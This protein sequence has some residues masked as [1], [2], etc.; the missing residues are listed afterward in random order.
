MLCPGV[1]VQAY[2]TLAF[3]CPFEGEVDPAQVFRFHSTAL[4]ISQ[5]WNWILHKTRANTHGPKLPPSLGARYRGVLRRGRGGRDYAG[6]HVGSGHTRTSRRPGEPSAA[7]VK[8]RLLLGHAK[9]VC[10]RLLPLTGQYCNNLLTITGQ[11][12]N[13]A[14]I[15]FG[16]WPEYLLNAG[17]RVLGFSWP[18][19]TWQSWPGT[20]EYSPG[21]R[22]WW[23]RRVPLSWLT[24]FMTAWM[25]GW[26][27]IAHYPWPP[28][29]CVGVRRFDASTSGCGGCNFVPD[30][31]GNV[32]TQGVVA[33]LDHPSVR[34][35]HS[36]RAHALQQTHAHL[37][38]TLG[39]DTRLD[40]SMYFNLLWGYVNVKLVN[41]VNAYTLPLQLYYMLFVIHGPRTD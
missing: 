33:V 8:G 13:N 21:C 26:V 16:T 17:R 5:Y 23:G 32:S 30:A 18:A 28:C 31:R 41:N 24:Q 12:C 10:S 34:V 19:S 15:F 22:A 6:R 7:G 25:R 29:T 38:R 14:N 2:A 4:G 1:R 20:A 35:P 37:Q 11:Y 36:V 9:K 3:G 40:P 27:V 39:P